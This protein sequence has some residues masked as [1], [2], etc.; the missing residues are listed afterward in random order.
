[1]EI[2]LI[3]KKFLKVFQLFGLIGHL[4]ELALSKILF[5]DKL[6]IN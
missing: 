2:F 6:R 4:T 5:F 3:S 1:M